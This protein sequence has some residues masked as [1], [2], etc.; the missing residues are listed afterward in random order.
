MNTNQKFPGNGS[1][2]PILLICGLAFAALQWLFSAEDKEKKP[3]TAPANTETEGRRKVAETTAFRQIPA[4]ISVKPVAVPM[5]S[6]PVPLISVPVSPVSVSLTKNV[7]SAPPKPPLK[8][9]KIITREDMATAFQC[10]A[11]A[12]TLKDAVAALKNLGFSKTAAYEALSPDGRFSTW[13]QF[14]P[15]GMII[16]KG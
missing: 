11:P 16:W 15:D 6:A 4:E 3:G 13:L 10:G 7:A 2:V 1:P 14:A 8:K 12:L 9:R 5:L